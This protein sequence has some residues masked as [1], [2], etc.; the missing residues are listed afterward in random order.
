VLNDRQR[1]GVNLEQVYVVIMTV[2]A[3]ADAAASR[4][5]GWVMLNDFSE[6]PLGI[7][8]VRTYTYTS[9]RGAPG[10]GGP[11]TAI[12]CFRKM[13]THRR[14]SLVLCHSGSCGADVELLM[15]LVVKGEKRVLCRVVVNAEQC[16]YR[17]TDRQ[18]DRSHLVRFTRCQKR[19]LKASKQR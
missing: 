16:R 13:D 9:R 5:G 2:I 12:D 17:S 18:T 1:Q 11:T 10:A 6:A 7:A 3:A 19:L 14:N 8:S 15:Q 4:V